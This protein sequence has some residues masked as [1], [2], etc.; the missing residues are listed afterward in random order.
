MGDITRVNVNMDT[1]E[2]TVSCLDNTL[3]HVMKGW[4]LFHCI[5]II[6][7]HLHSSNKKT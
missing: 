5:R 4:K 1:E 2:D 7:P 3:D 6:M